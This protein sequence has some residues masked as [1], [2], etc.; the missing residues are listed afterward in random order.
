MCSINNLGI[1]GQCNTTDCGGATCQ[2]VLYN[3]VA[4]II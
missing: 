3:P 1:L 4:V 2:L